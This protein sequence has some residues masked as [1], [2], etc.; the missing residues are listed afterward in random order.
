MT[1]Q[2]LD[3]EQ[4][5]EFCHRMSNGLTGK[6]AEIEIA[7]PDMGVQIEARWLPLIGV[8][9]DPKSDI[10]EIVLEGLD[11]MVFHPR[12]FYVDYGVAGIESLG[13]VDHNSVWQIVLLRDPLKLPAAGG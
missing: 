13:I 9:Y 6:R 3:R 11:H 7:S 10:I 4:W 12:E 5:S 2:K 1:L 8:A